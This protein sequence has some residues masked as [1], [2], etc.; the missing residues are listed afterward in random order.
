[1]P[2]SKRGVVLVGD[3]QAVVEERPLKPVGATDAI[4]QVDFCGICGSDLHAWGAEGAVYPYGTLM[5]HEA[6]GTVVEVG[7][8]VKKLAI[9]DRVAINGFTPCGECVACRDAIPNACVNNMVRTIADGLRCP[10]TV[11][12]DDA[13]VWVLSTG[14]FGA[15][16]GSLVYVPKL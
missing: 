14:D 1:M 4:V 9:G 11:V 6:T 16:D 3:K 8:D 2:T 5:G 7:K 10:N 15:D 13:G 12:V